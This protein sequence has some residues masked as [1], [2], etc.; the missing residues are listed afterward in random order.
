MDSAENQRLCNC[1][2]AQKFQNGQ[3][4]I[5]GLAARSMINMSL[6]S[7]DEEFVYCCLLSIIKSMTTK[8]REA[9]AINDNY[10]EIGCRIIKD[11]VVWFNSRSE[12]K[13]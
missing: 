7:I 6:S 4:V 9:L 3:G 2:V 1:Y 5:I 8:A 12:V 10:D 11:A 13:L